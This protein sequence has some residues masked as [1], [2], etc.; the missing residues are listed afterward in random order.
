MLC[1]MT[2]CVGWLRL[3]EQRSVSMFILPGFRREGNMRLLE[4]LA[5]DGLKEMQSR[6]TRFFF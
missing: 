6:V 5:R 2:C 1:V 3:G 4:M